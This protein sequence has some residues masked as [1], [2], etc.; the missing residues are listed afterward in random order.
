MPVID[1]LAPQRAPRG[2]DDGVV[3]AKARRV[4]GDCGDDAR[5]DRVDERAVRR[6]LDVHPV[7]GSSE[8]LHVSSVERKRVALLDAGE[9][10]DVREHSGPPQHLRHVPV[11]VVVGE[12]GAGEV[13]RGAAG[14]QVARGGEDCVSR[15]IGVR[16]AVVV[17]VDR[18]LLPRRRHELHPTDRPGRRHG[19]V[20]PVVGLDRVY[21]RE[22]PPGY[23]VAAPGLLVDG[24]QVGRRSAFDPAEQA[25]RQ[26]R[27]DG[28]DF[29]DVRER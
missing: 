23:V 18:P 17:G 26:P 27:E 10:R 11:G 22:H 7:V 9:G 1:V 12:D 21:C 16:V 24:N 28:W 20:A 6:G 14:L 3:G 19:E 13:A 8:L 2:F 5:S 25:G 4:A 15:R 29:G